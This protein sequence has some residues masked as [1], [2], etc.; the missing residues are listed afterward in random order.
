MRTT[1]E[2]DDDVLSLVK[3]IAAHRQQSIGKVISERVRASFQYKEETP[4]YRN[5][6]RVI[7]RPPGTPPVTMEMIEKLREEIGE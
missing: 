7:Q 4:L 6:L 2:I 3:D 5:G 1:L